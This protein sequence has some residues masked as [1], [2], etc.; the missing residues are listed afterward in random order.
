MLEKLSLKP[1]VVRKLPSFNPQIVIDCIGRLTN[2][3]EFRWEDNYVNKIERIP[4]DLF[5]QNLIDC[6]TKLS[7][8]RAID[9]ILRKPAI[10][11]LINLASQLDSL[12]K[13]QIDCSE[14]SVPSIMEFINLARKKS[15]KIFRYSQLVE[16]GFAKSILN[17]LRTSYK[18]P[19]SNPL[20]IDFYYSALDKVT[21]VEEANVVI[22]FT[23]HTS[24]RKLGFC[25]WYFDDYPTDIFAI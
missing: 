25:P 5:I 17:E 8:L 2:L 6:L 20:I 18:V 11:S 10:I 4:Y 14:M 13:F 23:V 15:L 19:P 21:T 1:L 7:K 12:E 22:Y 24:G 16:N 3:R 9:L